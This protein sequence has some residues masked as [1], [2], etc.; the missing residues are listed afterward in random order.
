[1]S[2]PTNKNKY[3]GFVALVGPPNA[4]K[5][6]LMNQLVGQKIA[7]TS[8]KPQ[9]TRHRILGIK[10]TDNAQ[11]VF[12]DTPGI[13]DPGNKAL[14][15]VI[16]KT[17]ISSLEDVDL[18]LFMIDDRGWN[19]QV[20]LAFSKIA[21]PK[22]P[23]VLI[24]NKVDKIKDKS[25]L[26]PLLAESQQHYSFKEI[27]PLSAKSDRDATSL[28]NLI[29][30]LLPADGIGFGFPEDQVTDKSQRFLASEFVRE[31]L[32]RQL[33]QELPYSTAVEVNQFELE[34]E[35]LLVMDMTIWVDRKGQKGIIVGKKGEK[36]KEIGQ[37]ARLQME[38]L[39]GVKVYLT[40]WVKVRSGWAN[41][42]S[43]LKSLG[44]TDH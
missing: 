23:V 18:I 14:N 19:A 10:T 1:M 11:V 20:E 27:F 22:V 4:G 35:K 15:K 13:H 3:F 16:N 6:T 38:R 43:M 21:S 42:A 17:A 36:L 24:I 39:F 9:T 26:L 34:D 2:N 44:Y 29:V 41:S 8:R 12:V 37:R 31:Q 5:S 25:T 28:W 40:L 32:F 30:P 7:I 33:G